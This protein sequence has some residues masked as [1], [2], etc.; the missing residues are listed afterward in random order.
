MLQNF[1]QIL[2]RAKELERVTVAVAAAQ[3][4]HALR[5]LYRARQEG[6]ADAILVGNQDKI[7]TALSEAK[8]PVEVFEIVDVDG[9]P[10]AQCARA[11]ELVVEGKAQVLM[12][13]LVDT[14]IL[15]KAVL[16]EKRLRTGRTMSTVAVME[17]EKYPKL[18]I[19]TD[20]GVLIA[21][22]LAQKKEMIINAQSIA[23]ALGIEKPKVAVICATEKVNPKM[24]DTLDAQALVEMNLRGELSGCIVGG[25]LSLDLAVSHE[26][27][28]DKGVDHPVAGDADILLVPNI[29]SG[30]VLY[31]SLAFL[32]E[33]TSGGTLVGAKVPVVINSRAD[34]EDTKLN[35]IAVATLMAANT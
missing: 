3:D 32:S 6:I 35:S 20:L 13:G 11:V 17:I 30:N 15:L 26:A 5:S 33:L 34:N 24:Q 14:S 16:N 31:K 21:P 1:K 28:R 22:D 27:A 2:R 10:A 9:D 18:L 8:I 29:V 12:K 25:P 4:P 19:L 23:Q 7:L